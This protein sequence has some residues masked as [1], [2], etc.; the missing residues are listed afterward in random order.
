MKFID[1]FGGIGG[2]RLGLEKA[3]EQFE[4]VDYIEY[5]K[6]AVKS[7]NAIF[8]EEHEPRDVTKLSKSEIPDHDLLCAGFPCQSF[9]V[10]G[11]RQ[12]TDE[13]RGKL[14]R[15]IARIAEAK[16]PEMLLLE[17]VKGIL[18]QKAVKDGES[19]E[20]TKGHA[21]TEVLQALHELG[22]CLEWQVLNSKN[23][24]VPQNRERVFIVGHLGGEPESKVFPIGRE[25]RGDSGEDGQLPMVLNHQFR[26]ETRPSIENGQS[27]GSGLLYNSNY[28]YALSSS[29][30]Y[31]TDVEPV[32]T[33]DFKNKDQN[34]TNRV[35]S[36]E[37]AMFTVDGTSIH[38][39]AEYQKPVEFNRNDG[40]GNELEVAHCLSSSDWRGLNRNQNQNAIV[41]K[42]DNHDHVR[43]RK[44]TPKECW[45]LQGFPDSAFDRAEEEN[46]DTQ[47]YKQA[48]NAVTVNVIE[49][50]GQEIMEVRS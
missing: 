38:G 47:L 36:Q 1:L 15:E 18:S 7:Y 26:P 41:K 17:N 2:F 42:E 40:I 6:Y 25:D 5:D 48:G 44:L 16:R 43:I 3:S 32:I 46:S 13:A 21:F 28:S 37:G 9:S 12:G 31:I 10:A 45:R 34:K 39:I 4:C 11:N 19:V 24:G 35:G 27:G 29:P 50:L 33:P 14:F 22:Y 30:H 8:K 49:A 23:W 20:G